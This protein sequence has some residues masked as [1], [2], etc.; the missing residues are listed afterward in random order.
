MDNPNKW[1]KL[2]SNLRFTHIPYSLIKKM[3][4]KT[5]NNKEYEGQTYEDF[6]QILNTLKT[7][8][9][10]DLVQEITL[11]TKNRKI[12]KETQ[13]YLDRIFSKM[14]KK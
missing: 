5:K 7:N 3:K 14:F 13:S 1:T 8:K 11:E 9:E 10:E 12:K 2:I 4:I 6:Q